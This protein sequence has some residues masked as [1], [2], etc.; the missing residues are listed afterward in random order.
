[1][2]REEMI[3]L[4]FMYSLCTVYNQKVKIVFV[5]TSLPSLLLPLGKIT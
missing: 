4:L 1:M 5:L 3:H 2:S